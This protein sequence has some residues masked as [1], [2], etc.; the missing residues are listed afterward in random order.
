MSIKIGD[1]VS[2]NTSQGQT[3]GRVVERRVEPFQFAKQQF[4]ASA[5]EPYFIVE[6]EK[7]GSK[8]AH[9]EG[10]LHKLPS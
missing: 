3:H 5:D 7:T 8:A 10:A 4:V 1:R 2:W 9:K 6:S